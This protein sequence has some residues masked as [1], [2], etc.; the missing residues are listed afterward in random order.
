VN[1]QKFATTSNAQATA[2]I[3]HLGDVLGHT[4]C[5]QLLQSR[6]YPTKIDFSGARKEVSKKTVDQKE[7]VLY[8]ANRS[9][10]SWR[11]KRLLARRGYHFEVI[12]ITND[13]LRTR[14]KRIRSSDYRGTVPYLFVDHRPVGGLGDIRGLDGSGTLELLVRGEV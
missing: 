7:M 5:L 10:R 14:L 4:S 3:R 1:F 2:K 9:L 6:A 8:T 12:C 13:G 11:A